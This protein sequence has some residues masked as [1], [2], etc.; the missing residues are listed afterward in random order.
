MSRFLYGSDWIMLAKERI[1]KSY[2]AHL[3]KLFDQEFNQSN[4]NEIRNNFI[5][6][7]A[8]LYLGLDK[9]KTVKRL[10]DF[11]NHNTIVI[12]HWLENSNKKQ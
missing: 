11:Y 1:S 4:N 2:F 10:K 5:G 9:P 6:G 7:N 3:V 8:Y 12:P